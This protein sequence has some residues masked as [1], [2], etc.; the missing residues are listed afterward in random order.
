[1][2]WL[3]DVWN[4]YFPPRKRPKARALEIVYHYRR[5]GR[6]N[7]TITIG[8]KALLHVAAVPVGAVFPGAIQWNTSDAAIVTVTPSADGLSCFVQ[9]LVPGTATVKVSSGAL[10]AEAIVTAV[11]P[12]ATG[13]VLTADAPVAA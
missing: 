9:P 7:L 1:M 12:A 8:F 5:S 11:A 13:L 3:W 2:K 6:M 10:S 4:K